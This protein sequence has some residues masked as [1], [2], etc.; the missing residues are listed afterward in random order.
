M[1][2]RDQVS[3][4]SM[5]SGLKIALLAVAL[6][7]AGC[8]SRASGP[9][10][11]SHSG[12]GQATVRAAFYY[13]WFPEAWDQLGINPFTKYHPSL[14]SYRSTD[15]TVITRHIDA[16]IY[17]GMNASIYSWWGQGSK[18]D[19][20]FD[21]YLAASAGKGLKWAAYYE[22][23]GNSS[24]GACSTASPSAAKIRSDLTYIKRKYS[25]HPNYLRID[26]KPVIFAYGDFADDCTT[27]DNWKQANSGLGFYVVLRVFRNYK[28]CPSQP[29][30]WHQYAPSSAEDDQPGYSIT[31]SPGFYKANEGTPRLSRDL[32]RW[33]KNVTDLKNSRAPLQLVTTFNEFGEGSSIESTTEWATSSGYGR[34]VDILHD[35]LVGG[36]PSGDPAPA[37][38][39]PNRSGGAL[40]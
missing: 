2:T 5:S 16:M 21:S 32:S 6:L 3:P 36:G 10:A 20:R 18:E 4:H 33:Q 17:A 25:S 31:I 1:V 35:V 13:P 37:S 40:Q 29:D 23:E 12:N 15:S 11:G 30:G 39:S 8:T 14:G 28:D 26:G 38:A 27:A 34:Y 9:G 24:G 19:V 7:L 22:C